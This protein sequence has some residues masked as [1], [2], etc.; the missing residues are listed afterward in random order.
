MVNIRRGCFETNSSSVHSITM[1][2]KK[3]YVEFTRGDKYLIKWYSA[4]KK[5]MTFDEVIRWVADTRKLDCDA[6]E[7][8]NKMYTNKDLEGV[9][10]YLRDYGI[11]SSSTYEDNDYEGFYEEFTTPDG[12]TVVSFGYYGESY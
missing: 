8:L 3:D 11:Y 7:E 4:P 1:C 9:A 12:E 5:F 6:V 10:D 2:M